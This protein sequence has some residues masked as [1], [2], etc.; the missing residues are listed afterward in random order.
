MKRRFIRRV[1]SEFSAVRSIDY[2]RLPVASLFGSMFS[3]VPYLSGRGVN[4]RVKKCD[5]RYTGSGGESIVIAL[6]SRARCSNCPWKNQEADATV[7]A[8][9]C[10]L[11][12]ARPLD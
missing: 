1:L 10:R 7:V 5:T 12:R 4:L 8:E 2:H 11:C 9:T 3:R 6:W